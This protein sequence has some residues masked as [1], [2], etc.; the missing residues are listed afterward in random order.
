MRGFSRALHKV[1]ELFDKRRGGFSSGD[2]V[3]DV[4]EGGGDEFDSG[5]FTPIIFEVGLRE[6]RKVSGV[7]R[8]GLW[9]RLVISCL[10]RQ[11]LCSQHFS[12]SRP[13][14]TASYIC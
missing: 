13:V 8:L 1:N 2:G 6:G 12:H 10:R 7:E 14:V 11:P 3:S 9:Y 4:E 5:Y